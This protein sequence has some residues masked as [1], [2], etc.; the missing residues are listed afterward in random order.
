M[1][2]KKP[3]HTILLICSALLIGLSPEM[4]MAWLIT[5][6][7][8]LKVEIQ[9]K[10]ESEQSK[11]KARAIDE[12]SEFA[13]FLKNGIRYFWFNHI[14]PTEHEK[15]LANGSARDKLFALQLAMFRGIHLAMPTLMGIFILK[16]AK[17]GMKLAKA[18]ALAPNVSILNKKQQPLYG[19][20]ARIKRYFYGQSL[21][22]MIFNDEIA[23]R[24]VEIE[25]KTVLLS[26]LIKGGKKRYYANLLLHG[27][28]GTGKTLF[29]QSLAYHTNMDFLPITAASLLQRGI[30][31]IQYFDELIDMANRSA[32]G[33]IIF[34][35]EADGLFTDR[36][37]LSPDS[38]HYKVLEHILS[39]IDG[40]SN[41]F[42][43]VAATN[44]AHIFD[45]AMNR[46][47]QDHV[48][49]QL[50]DK[51]TREELIAL[52]AYQIL[53]NEKETSN[54]FIAAAK[55]LL[56]PEVI[57]SIADTIDG[58]SH[59]EIAD[60]IEAMRAK[61]ELAD[62]I[63]NMHHVENAVKQAVAKNKKNSFK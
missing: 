52:Y 56:T 46:R 44:H 34:I 13:T 31:G 57:A 16:G 49:M 17:I 58:L 15:Q 23:D 25:K 37:L 63:L 62:Q 35:D 6:G 12:L 32:Y 10:V 1:K 7:E 19:R 38:D 50:P 14:V 20:M 22:H 51:I 61:A 59:A 30:K 3:L 48:L 47:F 4:S 29:A 28:S 40:R 27:P 36:T 2:K 39:V 43:I 9:E 45:A 42:M 5:N 26:N 18:H 33:A 21:Q 24:L 8:T 60:M 54:Q 53:F 11:A 55:A 41:K